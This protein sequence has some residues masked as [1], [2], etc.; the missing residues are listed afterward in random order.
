MRMRLAFGVIA[1]LFLPLINGMAK[2][3][4]GFRAIKV[5]RMPKNYHANRSLFTNLFAHAANTLSLSL[6]SVQGNYQLDGYRL[7]IEIISPVH[8]QSP[9]GSIHG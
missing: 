4:Q 5:L 6:S 8:L 3:W 1:R 7:F 9:I 2:K